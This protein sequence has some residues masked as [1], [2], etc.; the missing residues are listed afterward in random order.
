MTL[1][2]QRELGL[3]PAEFRR[4]LPYAL[5]SCRHW[6]D[7]GGAVVAETPQGQRITIQ[8]EGLPPRRLSASLTMPRCL[9]S[10]LFEGFDGTAIQTFM[11]NFDRAF[12]RGGG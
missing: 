9:V 1:S 11:A 12:Q 8:V 7:A 2:I 6:S 10:F 3:T 5:R 4:H